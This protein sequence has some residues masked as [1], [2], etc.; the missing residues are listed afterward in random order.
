[1][2]PWS[3]LAVGLALCAVAAEPAA[4]QSPAASS[5]ADDAALL[6]ADTERYGKAVKAAGVKPE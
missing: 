4:A 5:A 6:R 1:M 3:R 2:A